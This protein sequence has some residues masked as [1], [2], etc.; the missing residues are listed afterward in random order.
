MKN[1]TSA[2]LVSIEKLETSLENMGGFP[3]GGNPEAV[4]SAIHPTLQAMHLL[5][6]ETRQ[7]QVKLGES[8]REGWS[9]LSRG[10]D[11]GVENVTEVFLSRLA[12]FEN[13][14][15]ESQKLIQDQ[16]MRYTYTKK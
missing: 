16:V 13:K 1:D 2:I 10:I 15:I 12:A 5:V 7:S 8:F 6:N 14:T 3:S 9:S 4:S 11:Q